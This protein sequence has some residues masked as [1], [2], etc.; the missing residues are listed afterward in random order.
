M[1]VTKSILWN[2]FHLEDRQA[3]LFAKKEEATFSF[4]FSPWIIFFH[5]IL[6][7]LRP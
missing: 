1:P 6:K 7:K 5:F 3:I 2:K 4:I